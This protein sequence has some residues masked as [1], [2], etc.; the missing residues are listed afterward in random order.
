M[1]AV[2]HITAYIIPYRYAHF[3]RVCDGMQIVYK[4]RGIT[5]GEGHNWINLLFMCSCMIRH[6]YVEDAYTGKYGT[7]SDRTPLKASNE[8]CRRRATQTQVTKP[9]SS[10]CGLARPSADVKRDWQTNS[11]AGRTVHAVP[12]RYQAVT[13]RCLLFLG[14]LPERSR[15]HKWLGLLCERSPSV[16]IAHQFG[17]L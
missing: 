2:K 4:G 12:A 16:A 11:F 10:F 6:H 5:V 9:H 8:E 7:C 17:K 3:V 1:L 15:N 14:I 13:V